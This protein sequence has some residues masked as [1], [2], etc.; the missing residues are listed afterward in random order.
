M[1]I[2]TVSLVA[3]AFVFGLDCWLPPSSRPPLSLPE[4]SPCPAGAS[5]LPLI[6]RSRCSEPPA[7]T[8][9]LPDARRISSVLSVTVA[10]SSVSKVVTVVGPG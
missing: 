1:S 8:G 3:S 5:P 6:P 9:V 7:A 4:P 10:P 2:V